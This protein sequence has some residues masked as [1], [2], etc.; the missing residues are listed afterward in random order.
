M[1]PSE[2]HLLPNLW[3]KT[4]TMTIII[5]WLWTE[6]CDSTEVEG[7]AGIGKLRSHYKLCVNNDGGHVEK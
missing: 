4:P 3:E 6:I 5:S 1:A 2:I 7:T